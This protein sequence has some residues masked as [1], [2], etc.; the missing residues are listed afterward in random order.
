MAKGKPAITGM[1]SQG[2]IDD[3]FKGAGNKVVHAV[4]R[5]VQDA[6]HAETR[7]AGR[8]AAA[9][10]SKTRSEIAKSKK[11][12]GVKKGFAKEV[13]IK[14]GPDGKPLKGP[15]G[16]TIRVK[17]KIKTANPAKRATKAAN[18]SNLAKERIDDINNSTRMP[19]RTAARAEAYSSVRDNK[20][21]RARAFFPDDASFQ[22]ALKEEAADIRRATKGIKG[23]PKVTK[24]KK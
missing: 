2:I 4:R 19:K 1:H 18:K 23:G 15:D 22:R 8:T 16:K 6:V 20:M 7:L 10:K 12:A 17:P 5:Q 24:K 3:L 11:V 14:T 9:A 13:G 21:F